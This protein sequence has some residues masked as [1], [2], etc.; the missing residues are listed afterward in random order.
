MTMNPPDQQ[1]YMD[2]GATAHMTHN[3]GMISSYVNNGPR[4][5]IV[6]NGAPIPIQGAGNHTLPKPF[7]PFQLNQILYV[8]HI[9]KNLLS[10]RRFTKDNKLSI[11]F[12][13][14]G[15]TIKDLKTRIPLLR[16]NSSGDLYPLS[17][18]SSSTITP[19]S[20]FAALTQD[21]WHS[22]LGHPGS[23][24]LRI[25]HNNLSF[26][27]QRTNSI[28]EPCVLGKHVRLPF[29][30]SKSLV[31]APFDIIH[32]DLWTSPIVTNSGHRYYLLFLD[33][34]TNFLWTFPLAQK[35]QVFQTFKNFHAYVQTQFKTSIKSLQCDNGKEYDNKLFHDFC[36]QHG[37]SFRFSCPY[38]S[39]QN[40]KSERKIRSINNIIR[41]ILSQSKVPL[42]F[43]SMHSLMPH[44][45]STFYQQNH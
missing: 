11:E 20:T 19:P 12:D 45:F 6:G 9:I 39:S 38:T 25:L 35:S 18:R 22:R 4:N 14:F 40:G 2:S 16:C 15:F 34:Y 7:P 26:P 5:I 30:L 36:Q 24:I 33:D 41:T 3:P 42:S 1:W 23:S 32:S 13:P 44:I 29:H 43:G 27:F 31:F 8:P 28:C 21:L 37:I 10:V 17:F